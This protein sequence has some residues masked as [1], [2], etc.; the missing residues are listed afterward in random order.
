MGA[1]FHRAAHQ[2][3]EQGA[4]FPDPLAARILGEDAGRAVDE[5][6]GAPSKTRLRLFIA[7]RSR[8]AEDAMA[9]AVGGG[10][11]QVVVLGA[12]LDTCAYRWESGRAVRFFEVDHPATQAWK[13]E[14]LAQA[15]I[16]I[17]PRVTFAPVDFER[18]TLEDGLARAGFD[19]SRETFFTWL[20]VVPYLTEEAVFATLG[21]IG[22]LPGGG[23]VVF[24]Y[25]NP[26]SPGEGPYGE[27]HRE[28]ATRVA[29]I[30][31]EIRSHYETDDLHRR[32]R[33]L[34]YREVEDL[35]PAGMRERFFPAAP[36]APSDRG[37]H[38]LRAST[39]TSPHS[40]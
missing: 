32:L 40:A 27:A 12:G 38:V 33:S 16:P 15:R 4:I 11:S 21:F 8:F 35:G 24:D 10:A 19:P 22:G 39:V 17:P 9:A 28:L 23:H 26:P 6:K 3:L 13:R 18:G 7:I 29:R 5:A 30:G 36:R 34:G 2:V 37:G 1:A 25:G 31:E 20:G 14:M